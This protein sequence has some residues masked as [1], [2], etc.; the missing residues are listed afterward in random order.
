MFSFKVLQQDK[1][2][3]ARTAVLTTPYG[4][5]H[6]PAFLPVGTQASIKGLSPEEVKKT[7][8]EAVLANTYHLYLRPGADIVGKLGGLHKYMNWKGPVMTDSA[9]FQVFSLGFGIEHEVGKMVNLYGNDLVAGETLESESKEVVVRTKLCKIEEE[10]P[11]FISHLDG[12]AHFFPPEKSIETQIKLGADFI[13]CLDECTSPLH[14]YN[15]TK[16]AMERTHRWEKR[17]LQYFSKRSHLIKGATLKND[18]ALFG[19]I[20]GGPFKDLRI[21]SAKFV[22]GHDFFGVGI[23]GALVSKSKMKEILEWIYPYL[24][25]ERPRHLFGIGSV[26]DILGAVER[27]VDMFDCVS[28]TRLGRMGHVLCKFEIRNS[29]F[30]IMNKAARLRKSLLTIEQSYAYKP[31]KFRMDITKACFLKDAKPIDPDCGCYTC[32]NF[33]RAYLCHLFRAH[34]LFAYRLATIHNIYFMQSL[35]KEIREAIK[36]ERFEQVKG[37]WLQV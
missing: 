17:S 6:T 31:D 34:E 8:T 35:M 4:V 33:S 21:E 24:T 2:T 28:P 13:V 25:E 10:G 3:K 18:Q 16:A 20:Q 32:R 11:T 26:D 19:V 37:D 36:E 15:Y 22:A 9:G 1:K 5:I 27:G 23:G 7:G 14:D 29:K 30:E 12:S